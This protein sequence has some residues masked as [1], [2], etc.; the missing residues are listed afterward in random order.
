MNTENN[1]IG[2]FDSGVGGLTVLKAL[3]LQ[4]PKENFIYLGDTGRLPY[5]T[6]SAQTIFNYSQQIIEYLL[7]R[8]V[9]AIAIACNSAS[10]HYKLKKLHGIPIFNVIE[11]GAMVALKNS[12]SKVIGI[13]ETRA[14]VKSNSYPDATHSLDSEA[15]VF[16]QACPLLVP[17][18]EAGRIQDPITNLVAYRD[19]KALTQCNVDTI[20]L[21]CTHYPILKDSFQKTAGH[22]VTLVESG[23]ALAEILKNELSKKTW[24]A[25]TQ[26]S[27]SRFIELLTTDK[28]EYTINLAREILHP[29]RIS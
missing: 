28:S 14:T 17:L 13:L 12:K 6:K 27:A 25:N 4:F 23:A 3:A 1:P 20:V 2:V 8:K 10:S 21:G 19:I 11:P 22:S 29:I 26:D 7:N 16:Q 15:K 24:I 9:K 5:G 18:A